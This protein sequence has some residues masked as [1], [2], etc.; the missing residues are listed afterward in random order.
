MNDDNSN[1][2][3]IGINNGLRELPLNNNINNENLNQINVDDINI[4]IQKNNSISTKHGSNISK[5]E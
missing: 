3:I 4:E 2:N 5:Q 1:E